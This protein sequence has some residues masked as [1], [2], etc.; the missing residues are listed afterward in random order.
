MTPL[1]LPSFDVRLRETDGVVEIWDSFRKKWVTCTPEEWVRQHFAQYLKINLGYPGGRIALEVGF[2][3]N[4]LHKRADIVVYDEK[5]VPLIIA[6][7]K[8]PEVKLN[9]GVFE[10]VSRYN[11]AMRAPYLFV[12]NGMK[13][14]CA[15][16]DL[17]QKK[18]E[19][20]NEFPLHIG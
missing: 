19:F 15:K 4:Q 10:Q 14:F 8:A 2:L 7:C 9:N 1:A 20:M 6:E 12:T 3:V 16:V 17:E 5:G 18:W 13:H 11:L